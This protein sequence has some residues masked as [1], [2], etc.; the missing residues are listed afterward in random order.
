MH[1]IEDCPQCS[2]SGAGAL[3]SA[4]IA[5]AASCSRGA[6]PLCSRTHLLDKAASHG[7][8]DWF[9][10]AIP[11]GPASP[12]RQ[13]SAP[14]AQCSCAFNPLQIL[15]QPLVNLQIVGGTTAQL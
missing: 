6:N 1:P 5:I 4:V 14:S 8:N 2:Q 7:A 3:K 11:I 12:E 9:R 13:C 15:P 10:S